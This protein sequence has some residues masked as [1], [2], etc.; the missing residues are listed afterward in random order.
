[1]FSVSQTGGRLPKTGTYYDYP[2]V[3]TLH[4]ANAAVFELA[5]GQEY[6]QAFDKSALHLMT[7][8]K[9]E[10]ENSGRCL[11]KGGKSYVIVPSTEI[12]KKKGVFYL[13]A[14]FNQ[15]LRDVEIKRIFHPLDT[16][17]KDDQV[18][19][20]FIPE[21]AEKSIDKTPLWKIQLVKESLRYMMTDEDTG[22]AGGMED[23]MGD[24]Y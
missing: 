5:P 13:S 1:M 8:I 22:M 19:P 16:N 11:L 6:L 17:T 20:N 23:G 12:A 14:Y 2:F 10:R 9:R 21:E 18:L 7:P 3:E 15:R 4:Y 24:A